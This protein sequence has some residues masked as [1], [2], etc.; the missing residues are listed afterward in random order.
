M[1]ADHQPLRNSYSHEENALEPI[2]SK[3]L[4]A[5][6]DE[7]APFDLES[8]LETIP[9]HD[10]SQENKESGGIPIRTS[11]DTKPLVHAD[12]ANSLIDRH[13]MF[14]GVGRVDTKDIRAK[15]HDWA[16]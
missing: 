12:T 2:R 7:P 4:S 16:S 11:S 13:D 6:P 8:R 1:S 5:I 9:T 3:S 15:A 10:E 14:K